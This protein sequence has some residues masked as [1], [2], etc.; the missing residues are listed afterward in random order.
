MVIL[1]SK[2]KKRCDTDGTSYPKLQVERIKRALIT[3]AMKEQFDIVKY[4]KKGLVWISIELKSFARLTGAQ[5]AAIIV[6]LSVAAY[7]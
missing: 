4:T 2:K 1:F 7:R 5:S 3:A 6:S